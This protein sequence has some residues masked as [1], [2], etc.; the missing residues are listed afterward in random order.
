ML[1]EPITTLPLALPQKDPLRVKAAELEAAFLSEMLAHAGL[2]EEENG[3]SG[4]VGESQ[5]ASFLRQ[6]QAEAMVR[7]GGIG[8]AET[9]FKALSEASDGKR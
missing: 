7:A 3:F 9:L 8:L 5:F 1:T 4:G 6:E 2:G